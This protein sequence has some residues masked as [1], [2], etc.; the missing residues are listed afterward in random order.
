[1]VSLANLLLRCMHV[2]ACMYC[3]PMQNLGPNLHGACCFRCTLTSTVCDCVIF[4]E[5]ALMIR[6][7]S[8]RP[9]ILPL[10]ASPRKDVESNGSSAKCLGHRMAARARG[11]KVGVWY[12][13][14]PAAWEAEACMP[15][16]PTHGHTPA[17]GHPATHH[18]DS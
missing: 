17:R 14:L 1:M 5:R 10:D 11:R 7:L 13:T 3:I 4:K 9:T 16:S 18:V 12:G 8:S 2:H 15:Y 6:K